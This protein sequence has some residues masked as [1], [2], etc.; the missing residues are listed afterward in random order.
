MYVIVWKYQ[1]LADSEMEFRV[2]YGPDG[3]WA[4]LFAM[5]DGF[6]GTE[7]ITTDEPRH[8]LTIDQ[9]D[10]AE[11][12]DAYMERDREEYRRLDQRFEALTVS[13]KLV[14]RGSTQ[15]TGTSGP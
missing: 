5:H 1:V 15:E 12:F 10:S 8:Y 6:V 4:R 14:G 11:A 9:W 7:L 2:A 13:E 3:D